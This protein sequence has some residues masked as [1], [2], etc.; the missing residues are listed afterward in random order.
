MTPALI[1]LALL[2]AALALHDLVAV[3]R[4]PRLPAC[5]RDPDGGRPR[6]DAL[7]AVRDDRDDELVSMLSAHARRASHAGRGGGA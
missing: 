5:P 7:F 2:W 3:R 4:L 1:A 6:V